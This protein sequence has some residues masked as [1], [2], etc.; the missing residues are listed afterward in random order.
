M[1]ITLDGKL[2]VVTGAAQ[3]IG[4]AIAKRLA[5]CGA[6]VVVNDLDERRIATAVDAIRAAIPGATV[7]GAAADLSSAAGCNRLVEQVP[8]CDILVNNAAIYETADFFEIPDA[9]WQRY[10]EPT[11]CP[12]SGCRGPTC[13]TWARATGARRIHQFRVRD[14]HAARHAALRGY[15]DGA[16]RPVAR[17]RET[18][19]G[20]RRH[21]ERG[22]SGRR[23]AKASWISSKRKSAIPARRSRNKARNSSRRCARR[24]SRDA[25]RRSTKWRTL[26]STCSPLASATTGAALRADGGVAD[27][28]I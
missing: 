15:Q 20:H 18:H 23:S 10:F 25:S 8:D 11:S 21:G 14:Q 3:G 22:P 5:Q 13:R 12:G 4:H 24:R 1:Q 19:V 2:A 7:R 17:P 27:T 6:Q 28:P 9:T 16:L 26:C